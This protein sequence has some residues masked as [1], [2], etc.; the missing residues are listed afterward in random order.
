MSARRPIRSARASARGFT[1]AEMLTV[2]AII[3]VLAASASP[4]FINM[5]R[6]RRVNRAA[7]QVV[8]LVRMARTRS[9]GRNLPIRVRWNAG[10]GTKARGLMTLE[11]PII[12]SSATATNCGNTQWG[13]VTKVQEIARFDL[14]IGSNNAA[15]TD[16]LYERA[17]VKFINNS[18]AGGAEEAIVEICFSGT[19]RTYVN[20]GGFVPLTKVP[21]FTI[22]NAAAQN[23]TGKVRTVYIPPTGVARLAL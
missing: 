22:T 4:I 16:G 6:D 12:V 3:A 17:D 7:M 14:A 11:E 23:G 13:D 10:G 8:E 9:I 18:A 2:V 21:M 19:G 5:M 15:G 1:M 20:I